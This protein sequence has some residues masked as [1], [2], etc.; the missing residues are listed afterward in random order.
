MVISTPV[1]FSDPGLQAVLP[2]WSDAL[3]VLG[4]VVLLGS[5]YRRGLTYWIKYYRA[6][7]PIRESSES[8]RRSDA[9]RLLKKREGQVAAGVA[10]NPR[11][12]RVLIDDLFEDLI[13]DYRVR[14]HRTLPDAKR[15]VRLHLKPFW[16]GSRAAFIRKPHVD[17]Y[18]VLR[19]DA[20]A[21]PAT[22]NRELALLRRAI[23]LG[24]ESGKLNHPARISLLPEDSARSG[25]FSDEQMARVIRELPEHLQPMIRFAFVT[26]WRIRS[27]ILPLEWRQVDFSEGSVRLDAGKTK[28]RKPRLFP[29]TSEIR[30]LLERQKALT[31][32]VQRRRGAVVRWVFHRDGERIRDFYGAWRG[33][34]RR[35]GCP[36]R[37][38]H[39][40]RR[41]AVRNMIKSGLSER[42]AMKLTGHETRTIFGRYLIVDEDDLKLAVERLEAAGRSPA[43]QSSSKH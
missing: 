36:G 38:P 26:G 22:I 7:R 3:S 1:W 19:Q 34:C 42:V 2:L 13:L 11:A 10:F 6:G 9:E 27:E 31:D 41:T 21:S 20:G 5:I 28:N 14:N 40:L 18:I 37:I 32:A 15:R 8:R 25:F 12:D 43:L 17:R 35:A 33:G 39:D 30:E 23:N 4:P 16:S 24:H 29:M